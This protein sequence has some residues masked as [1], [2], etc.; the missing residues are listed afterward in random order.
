MKDKIKEIT[1]LRVTMEREKLARDEKSVQIILETL[2]ECEISYDC[3]TIHIDQLAIVVKESE[4]G[5]LVGCMILLGRKLSRLNI[6][7]DRDI[8]LLYI[9]GRRLSCRGISMIVSGLTMQD[10]EM[11]MQRY[12]RCR[13]RFIIGVS[14]DEAEKAKQAIAEI[15]DLDFVDIFVDIF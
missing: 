1:A 9:E 2:E 4:Y 8:M 11:K 13:N 10:I 7:I 15:I 12:L 14:M 3:I 6:Y 5:K